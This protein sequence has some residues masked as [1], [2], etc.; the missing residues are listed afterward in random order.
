MNAPTETMTRTTTTF[1]IALGLYASQVLACGGLEQDVAGDEAPVSTTA[2]AL[3]CSD[4]TGICRTYD[5]DPRTGLIR[6]LDDGEETGTVE[7]D[8]QGRTF[9]ATLTTSPKLVVTFETTPVGELA[10]FSNQTPLGVFSP[11]TGANQTTLALVTKHA[12]LVADALANV[13]PPTGAAPQ[14]SVE[15][16]T[17]ADWKACCVFHD[18][19]CCV[20]H[21]EIEWICAFVLHGFC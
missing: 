8:L 10:V 7:Y 20:A 15:G 6:V 17:R 16:Q 9:R 2:G 12:A 13:S 11:A 4:P 3:T 18:V 14:P 1:I 21:A 5:H 19:F